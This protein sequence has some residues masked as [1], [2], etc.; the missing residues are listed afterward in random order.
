MTLAAPSLL[1]QGPAASAAVIAR[2]GPRFAP[3]R[4]SPPAVQATLS[5][6]SPTHERPY[7]YAYEPPPGAAW[8]NYRADARP[9]WIRDARALGAAP[10]VDREGFALWEAPSSLTDPEDFADA[11][12][13]TER[14]YPEVAELARAATGA[15]HAYVFDHLVRRRDAQAGPLGF[16]RPGR[17]QPAGANGRVHNDYTETS[18]RRRLRLVLGEAAAV[19]VGRYAIVNVWRSLSGPVLD[20]PLALC[21]ARSV[22]AADL[23]GADVR[24]PNRTGDIY[25]ML[26]SPRHR[27][28]HFSA[29]DRHEALVFKQYD[30][31]ISGVARFTPHA[32]FDH[33]EA[34]PDAPPRVSIEARCLVI[35]D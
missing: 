2:T 24:Y 23:V 16:G 11:A 19:G 21:D 15:P 12:L 35:Y 30:S 28:F 26:H 4:L 14:Y 27:W 7:N 34:P 10:L 9:V 3:A 5:Y 13:V 6:L 33:P 18:G 22:D 17:G 31:S 8:E 20:T 32:A 25:L 1:P 29:M